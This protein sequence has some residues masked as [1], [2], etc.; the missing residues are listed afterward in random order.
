MIDTSGKDGTIIRSGWMFGQV[1]PLQG[2][3]S[4]VFGCVLLR[5]RSVP[6]SVT[7]QEIQ[8]AENSCEIQQ[9]FV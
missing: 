9:R 8:D 6:I 2:W 3:F 1:A 4:L 7:N 5:L